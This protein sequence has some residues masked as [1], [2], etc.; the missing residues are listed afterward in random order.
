MVILV[1]KEGKAVITSLVDIALKVGGVQNLQKVNAII[2]AVKEI[3]AQKKEQPKD[4]PPIEEKVDN[5][6]PEPEEK[7]K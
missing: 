1:D 6:N 4:K 5:P 7:Q 3:P 2:S